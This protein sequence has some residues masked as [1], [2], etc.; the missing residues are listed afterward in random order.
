MYSHPPSD[1][2]VASME[3]DQE[4]TAASKQASKQQK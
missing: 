2:D 3:R 4:W 1:E